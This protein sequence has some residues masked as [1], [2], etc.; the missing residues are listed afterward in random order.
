MGNACNGK[1]QQLSQRQDF[2]EEVILLHNL[3]SSIF[4]PVRV[5][6]ENKYTKDAS[7][8]AA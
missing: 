5:R 1:R 2:V 7:T 3:F 6:D 4:L 8:L